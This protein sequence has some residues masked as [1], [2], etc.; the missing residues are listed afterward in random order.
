MQCQAYMQQQ[1]SQTP[2]S[3]N[4]ATVAAP[5]HLYP[6]SAGKQQQTS[7]SSTLNTN[8]PSGGPIS[9]WQTWFNPKG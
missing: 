9:N 6:Q 1:Q 5:S 7:S 4:S 3:T 8:A 2:T